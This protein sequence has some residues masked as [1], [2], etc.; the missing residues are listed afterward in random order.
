LG[1]DVRIDVI[2]TVYDPTATRGVNSV[3]KATIEEV[4][5]KMNPVTDTEVDE[6]SDKVAETSAVEKANNPVRGTVMNAPD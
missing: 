3:T 4:S 1:F 5:R 6:E 2:R